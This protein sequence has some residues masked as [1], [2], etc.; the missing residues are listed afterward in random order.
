M[1]LSKDEPEGIQTL[2]DIVGMLY[3]RHWN[4]YV[5]G[6]VPQRI[7][8]ALRSACVPLL[9]SDGR[10]VLL[11]EDEFWDPKYSTWTAWSGYLA[12]ART[13]ED[14]DGPVCGGRSRRIHS[15]VAPDLE[16]LYGAAGLAEIV[17]DDYLVVCVTPLYRVCD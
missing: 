13:Y 11:S 3:K 16:T 12:C 4:R 15:W 10:T 8:D 5:F 1:T 6:M 2:T 14:V 7:R 9:S 17:R